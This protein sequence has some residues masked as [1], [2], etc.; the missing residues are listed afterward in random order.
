MEIYW[1]FEQYQTV[2]LP[3]KGK[4]RSGV[5]FQPCDWLK[6]PCS[7]WLWSDSV[8]YKSK[9][10]ADPQF[11]QHPDWKLAA[12]EASP[13][14]QRSKE[15]QCCWRQNGLQKRYGEYGIFKMLC[16]H[17]SWQMMHAS[18]FLFSEAWVR[19]CR[20]LSWFGNQGRWLGWR[21]RR[22]TPSL[23]KMSTFF[24]KE[25]KLIWVCWHFEGITSVWNVTK[26]V[27]RAQYVCC[28]KF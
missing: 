3:D 2:F 18:A 11:T 1:K 28:K 21:G 23:G 10:S 27:L 20:L 5:N 16:V 7:I 25:N 22:V 12:S 17:K 9:N 19:I 14:W 8:W 6:Q 4:G 26:S 24:G 13:S 15:V